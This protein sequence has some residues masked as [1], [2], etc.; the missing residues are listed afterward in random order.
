MIFLKIKKT[1]QNFVMFSVMQTS[2]NNPKKI[3]N[4]DGI[5]NRAMESFTE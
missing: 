5:L 3:E 2:I 4:F 1:L